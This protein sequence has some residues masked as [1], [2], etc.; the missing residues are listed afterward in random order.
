MIALRSPMHA[1]L[2]K[3]WRTLRN[4][5]WAGMILGILLPVCFIA[6]AELTTMAARPA[7]NT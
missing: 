7:S 3:E 6:G 4:L 1:L 5:R 2:W